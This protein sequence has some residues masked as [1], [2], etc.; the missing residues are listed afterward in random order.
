MRRVGGVFSVGPPEVLSRVLQ[1]EVRLRGADSGRLPAFLQRHEGA[2]LD[3]AA[4]VGL[5]TPWRPESIPADLPQPPEGRGDTAV[6]LP[7]GAYDRIVIAF[8][9]GKDSLACVL[10]LWERLE[11]VGVDPRTRLELWHYVI[12][13]FGS[14][15]VL[16]WAC[17]DAYCQRVAAHLG[18]P[19][20]RSWREG[21]FLREMQRTDSPTAPVT[22]ELATGGTRTVGGTG[23][24]NTRSGA[25]PQ[26]SADLRV[27]WCSA[28]LKIMVAQAR[29]AHDP[30]YAR[31]VTVLFVT[32]ER[33]QESAGR[34]KYAQVE[35]SRSAAPT[36]R[37]IVHHYRP[38]LGWPME[39]VW[40]VIQR[41]GIVPHPCYWL[42]F[43]RCS[44]EACVFCRAAE[45]ATIR[46]IHPARF[47]QIAALEAASGRTIHRSMS[48]AAQAA[49]GTALTPAGLVR[50]WWARQATETFDAPVATAPATWV[51]PPGGLR[52]GAGAS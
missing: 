32:G 44:C 42:G 11:H 14:P 31:D 4:A 50:A 6:L 19:I 33:R 8:S 10:D 26:V 28:Y 41:H 43:G 52:V 7:L 34:S 15:V 21:G 46:D 48:V 5:L 24:R 22:F 23:P 16:D 36:K 38:I 2:V 39:R 20:Y 40:A 37:R 30:R 13:G 1:D 45:W 3:E 12:D 29:L 35:A 49:R 27:R 25:F 9:G 51:L 18:L 17:T 47:V